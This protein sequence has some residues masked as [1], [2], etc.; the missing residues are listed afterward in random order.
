MPNV[1]KITVENA[2]ELLNAG[3]YDA[4][5]LI[6]I[7]SSTTETQ[8]GTFA[9]I[10]GTGS[11]P[12]I[13]IVSGTR[14]YTGYDPNGASSTWYRTRYKNAAGSRASDWSASFQ[15]GDETAGMLCSVYDVSQRMF[16]T[17][18]P[19][20]S[21]TED[22]LNIIREVS[23]EIEDYV[24]AWLAPR[25]TD[26]NSSTTLLFDVDY[27][28]RA[29]LLERGNR[30]VGIR[31]FTAVGTAT[32]SQPET[33]GTFTSAT[34]ADLLM[35][36]RPTT[37][38]PGSYLVWNTT[39]GGWFYEGFNTVTITG[40]FGPAS[41]APRFQA[42]AIA[43]VTRRFLGKETSATAISLGPDGAVRLL[44]DISP[45]MK[46]TLDRARVMLAG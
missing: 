11:T 20:D 15:V 23:D 29:L 39:A 38:G 3:A 18:T 34:L 12:T 30:R 4:G 19:S 16:G 7:Q 43:A 31:S 26:P 24:G 46:A 13:A 35:R 32:Q 27:T 37:D 40:S 6:Q 45:S 33:G 36:P 5:A 28:C 25:P 8:P 44:G 42:V 14:T 21:Q 1:L 10:S 2:S 17:A 9:D 22:I 41:V